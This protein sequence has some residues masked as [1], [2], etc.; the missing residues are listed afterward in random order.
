MCVCV[1]VCICVNVYAYV[2]MYITVKLLCRYSIVLPPLV[3]HLTKITRMKMI[4][5][6]W[7]S[8]DMLPGHVMHEHV[9]EHVKMK[10]AQETRHIFTR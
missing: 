3:F 9:K 8:T 2:Y 7:P 6:C 5:D 10:K 1:Y 4:R